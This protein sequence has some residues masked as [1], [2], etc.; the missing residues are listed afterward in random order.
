MKYPPVQVLDAPR[1]SNAPADF[2]DWQFAF[3][4]ARILAN[5][6]EDQICQL[7]GKLLSLYLPI[8]YS[9]SLKSVTRAE[10]QTVADE[11]NQSETIFG[12][13]AHLLHKVEGSE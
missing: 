11:L 12:A 9:K 3:Y 10:A 5:E 13:L 6:V 2:I 8:R 1:P 7:L 4:K